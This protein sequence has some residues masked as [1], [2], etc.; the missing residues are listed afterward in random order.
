MGKIIPNYG[1]TFNKKNFLKSLENRMTNQK[2]KL[3]QLAAKT[4]SH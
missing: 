1:W 3:P 2:K 4:R